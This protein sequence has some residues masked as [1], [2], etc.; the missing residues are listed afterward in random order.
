M[1]ISEQSTRHEDKLSGIIQ[2][3]AKIRRKQNTLSVGG[4]NVKIP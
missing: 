1:V 2:V 4:G 3:L